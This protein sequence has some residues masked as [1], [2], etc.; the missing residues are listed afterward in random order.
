MATAG[1]WEGAL[2]GLAA[3]GVHQ[4]WQK[5]KE[6]KK[7]KEVVGGL[8][9]VL[10]VGLGGRA[11]AQPTLPETP[12]P[13]FQTRLTW[14]APTQNTDGSAL[15]D[16]AGYEV[17]FSRMNDANWGTP[18]DVPADR[19]AHTLTQN[20][21]LPETQYFF[22]VRAYNAQGVRSNFSNIAT[23]TTPDVN[24]PN[25]PADVVVEI[26]FNVQLP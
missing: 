25:P 7:G 11:E 23:A 26:L 5:L 21:L 14:V 24:Q 19:V 6:L 18:I 20:Q 12:V 8:L 2:M 22:V 15:T 1:A 16:L 17:F 3:T 10:A 13:Q 4:L 9:V